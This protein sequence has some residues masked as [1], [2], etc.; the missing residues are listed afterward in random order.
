[1]LLGI[2]DRAG[3]YLVSIGVDLNAPGEAGLRRTNKNN[4]TRVTDVSFR[5]NLL[6]YHRRARRK[7]RYLEQLRAYCQ[8]TGPDELIALVEGTVERDLSEGLLDMTHEGMAERH[9]FLHRTN[10]L[11]GALAE[12]FNDYL[13][14]D[15]A[16]QMHFFLWLEEHPISLT[17]NRTSEWVYDIKLVHYVGEGDPTPGRFKFAMLAFDDG[18]LKSGGQPMDTLC[19][20]VQGREGKKALRRTQISWGGALRLSSGPPRTNCSS[21]STLPTRSTTPVLPPAIV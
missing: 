12:A 19:G 3:E 1:M 17:Q 21:L 14:S 8:N 10:F 11:D 16:G 13:G 5:R 9:D 7:A 6:T 4:I 20:R 2:S 18:I 15:Q